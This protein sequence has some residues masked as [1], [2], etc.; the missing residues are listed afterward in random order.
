VP[1]KEIKETTFDP[2]TISHPE[3]YQALKQWRLAKAKE[4]GRPA[5]WV[6]HNTTLAGISNRLP[7]TAG[8]LGLIKGLKG[9]KGQALGPEILELVAQYRLKHNLPEPDTV[10]E[11]EEGQP[12]QSKKKKP[13][14]KEESLRLFLEGRSPAEAASIRGLTLTTIE[15]HLAHF[16]G[17][18]KLGLERLM[19][20][21]KAARIAAYFQANQYQGL[22]PAKE[23][24]GPDVS[25]GDLRFVL[26]DLERRRK[27][28]AGN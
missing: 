4:T 8:E 26:K 9:K 7:A 28:K 27:L 13:K 23:A 5:F 21:E 20:P 19:A 11:K 10:Q 15:G 24:L 17:T 3:L 16:V 1:A 14:T 6:L 22:T 2:E 25:Y 12:G 18:G